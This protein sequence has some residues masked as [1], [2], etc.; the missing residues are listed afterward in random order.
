MAGRNALIGIMRG[1][2]KSQA[3]YQK[4]KA[5]R[6][7]KRQKDEDFEFKK[8]IYKLKIDKL[9]SE[10]SDDPMLKM[11]EE[12]IG[13]QFKAYDAQ[14][15][16]EDNQ[17]GN[18]ERQEKERGE[19]LKRTGARV[20]GSLMKQ[21]QRQLDWS[22]NTGSRAFTIKPQK[23]AKATDVKATP[24]EKLLGLLQT[25]DFIDREEAEAKAAQSGGINWKQK[26]PEAVKILDKRYDGGYSLGEIK[27]VPG[28][29]KWEY[30]GD[31]RWKKVK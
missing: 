27:D 25:G 9:K 20:A 11:L 5:A 22:Y 29:G 4:I 10:T 21:Q 12:Q 23:D 19:T 17:I 16:V 18:A 13:D 7:T 15:K 24:K 3:N 6:D 31:N 14:S 2:Q 28:K 26:F 8:K 30:T 1:V